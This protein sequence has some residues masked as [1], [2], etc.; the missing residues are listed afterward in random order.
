MAGSIRIYK[1]CLSTPHMQSLSFVLFAVGSVSS[2]E[3]FDML[4]FYLVTSLQ[5]MY[6]Y[7]Y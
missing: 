1:P 5:Y 2:S 3:T 7:M 6:K 4:L